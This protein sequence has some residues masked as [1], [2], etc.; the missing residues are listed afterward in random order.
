[1]NQVVAAEAAALG[2]DG[3]WITKSYMEMVLDL[4]G[5]SFFNCLGLKIT[6]GTSLRCWDVEPLMNSF[7]I[8]KWIYVEFSCLCYITTITL[9]CSSHLFDIVHC[10]FFKRGLTRE[11]MH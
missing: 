4:K 11:D 10:S 7:W 1:L 3:P 2:L 9:T 5:R 8:F 6:V